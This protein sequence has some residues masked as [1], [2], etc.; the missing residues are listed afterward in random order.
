MIAKD[1]VH[2]GRLIAAQHGWP[3]AKAFKSYEMGEADRATIASCAVQLLAAF[4]ATPY[5]NAVMSGAFAV[6]LERALTAP[7]HVVAG[8]LAV[9]GQP[10]FGDRQ[11]FDGPAIFGASHP[12]FHGHV[13]VM[14]GPYVADISLFRSAYSRSGPPRLSRHVDLVFG[15]GKGLYVDDWQRCRQRGLSY[16]PQ[17]VLSEEEVTRLM[18][19]AFE[20]IEKARA[21]RPEVN[22]TVE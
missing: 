3:A 16:E 18:G 7:V 10:V 11:P 14:I 13:W 21:E 9:E 12:E 20:I 2:L 4:P 17:Y 8:T 19:G 1:L 15:P 6:Q 5:A 22:P